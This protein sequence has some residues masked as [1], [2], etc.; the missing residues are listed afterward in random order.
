MLT[1]TCGIWKKNLCRQSYLHRRNIE[2]DIESKCMAIK[3]GRE[4]WDELG[5]W[6]WYIYTHTHTHTHTH[7]NDTTYI[8]EP[9]V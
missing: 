9:N 6:D 3:G 5:D 4:K 1:H 7:T 8:T 2:T